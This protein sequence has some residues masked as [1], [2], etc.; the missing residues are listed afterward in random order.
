VRQSRLQLRE[1]LGVFRAPGFLGNDLLFTLR[2]VSLAMLVAEQ[3]VDGFIAPVIAPAFASSGTLLPSTGCQM[4][5]CPFFANRHTNM[6][7]AI[8]AAIASFKGV[9]VPGG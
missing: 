8:A 2:R 9:S 6:V 3:A 1:G 7:F 4:P 5:L